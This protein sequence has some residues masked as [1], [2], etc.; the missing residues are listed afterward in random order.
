MATAATPT[1][2][3]DKNLP[4]ALLFMDSS[5]FEILLLPENSGLS[6]TSL[7]LLAISVFFPVINKFIL[8]IKMKT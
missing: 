6:L 8:R 2:C 5:D 1:K 7:V 4:S 3:Y